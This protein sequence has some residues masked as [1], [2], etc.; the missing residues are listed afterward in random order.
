MFI[1]EAIQTKHN[2]R[3][4]HIEDKTETKEPV[5]A[6]D[7]QVPTEDAQTPKEEEEKPTPKKAVKASAKKEESSDSEEDP[8]DAFMANLEKDA[9]SKGVKAAGKFKIIIRISIFFCKDLSVETLCSLI[10]CKRL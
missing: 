9:K 7:V 4:S 1:R 8:L 5:A 10:F 6:G 2:I 3:I